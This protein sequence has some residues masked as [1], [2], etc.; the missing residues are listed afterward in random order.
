MIIYDLCGGTGSWSKPYRDAGYDVRVI[1]MPDQDV[2]L[3]KI[4]VAPVRGVLAAP[5]CTVFA[6]SGNRWKRTDDEMQEGLSIV[7][8]CIRFIFSTNPVW[9]CLEN[10]IGTL[11]R[12]LGTPTMQK[13][14]TL[15]GHFV[16]SVTHSLLPGTARLGVLGALVEAE[17]ESQPFDFAEGVVGH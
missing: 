9:W 15:T 6:V 8:A 2:R 17:H 13:Q 12:W 3:L 1:T 4:P 14:L 10:P 7:D 11:R 16:Q 5:P